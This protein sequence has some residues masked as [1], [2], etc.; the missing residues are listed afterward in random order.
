MVSHEHERYTRTSVQYPV[1]PH[2]KSAGGKSFRYSASKMWNRLPVHLRIQEKHLTF[3]H[4]VKKHMWTEL[5]R[6]IEE[7]Y[8]YYLLSLY[9]ILYS[10]FN[11]F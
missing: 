4:A 5:E 8:I 11:L 3:K 1:L 10:V 6:R 9:N 2:V 7:A